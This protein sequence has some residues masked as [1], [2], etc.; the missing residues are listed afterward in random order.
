[1]TAGMQYG[2]QPQLCQAGTRTRVPSAPS[3]ATRVWELQQ[4][5]SPQPG[6]DPAAGKQLQ[7][8]V[9]RTDHDY[10]R[11]PGRASRSCVGSSTACHRGCGTAQPATATVQGAGSCAWPQA[12]HFPFPTV[13]REALPVG[14]G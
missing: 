10:S 11:S 12:A 3:T 4:G 6:P 9:R 13:S 14:H 1:M 7:P 2:E 8:A 5:P